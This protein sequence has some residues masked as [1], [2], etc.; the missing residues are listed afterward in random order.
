MSPWHA[1][2]RA[3]TTLR[4]RSQSEP[5]KVVLVLPM[6]AKHSFKDLNSSSWI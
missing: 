5:D 3:K 2:Q 6:L 4:K 1:P